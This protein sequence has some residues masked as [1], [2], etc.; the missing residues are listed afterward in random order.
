MRSWPWQRQA[1]GVPGTERF[2][3]LST[4]HSIDYNNLSE[5]MTL[6]LTMQ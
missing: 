2:C 5:N 1:C 6:N 3:E 4:E